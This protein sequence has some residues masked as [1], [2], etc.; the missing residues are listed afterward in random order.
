MHTCM[1]LKQPR[2]VKTENKNVFL[3]QCGYY[4]SDNFHHFSRDIDRLCNKHKK[5]FYWILKSGRFSTV[6]YSTY[7]VLTNKQYDDL[8]TSLNKKYCAVFDKK[9]KSLI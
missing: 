8:P 4:L 6:L 3:L 7:S 9:Q 2:L 1:G 5:T